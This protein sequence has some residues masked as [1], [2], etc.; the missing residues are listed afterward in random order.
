MNV[1]SLP[2]QKNLLESIKH[3][4]YN[5]F[6]R[7]EMKKIAVPITKNNQIEAHFRDCEFYEIY[8]FSNTNEIL[9]LQLLDFEQGCCSKSNLVDVLKTR[10]VSFMLSASIGSKAINKLKKAGID[11]IRGCSGDS[12]D[13]ILQFIEGK[14][15]DTG[16]SCLKNGHNHRNRPKYICNH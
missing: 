14:I 5:F 15:S 9:D 3:K 13:A 10:G 2:L 16:I 1:S 6:K 12:A 11:V 7:L 8:T 4:Y